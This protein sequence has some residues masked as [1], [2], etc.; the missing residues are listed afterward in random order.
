MITKYTEFCLFCGKPT[1]EEHHL[2]FGSDRKKADED[3]LKVP[4]CGGCHTRNELSRR[5]HDNSM[6]E[7]LSKLCGQLAYEKK[8][9]AQGFTEEEARTAFRMRYGRSFL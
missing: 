2:L 6:A 5:I 7:A 8:L 3:D 1:D 4:I 9:V